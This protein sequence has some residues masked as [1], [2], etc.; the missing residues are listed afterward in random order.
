[1]N[2]TRHSSV[3]F[4]TPPAT[5]AQVDDRRLSGG[6]ALINDILDSLDDVVASGTGQG[7]IVLEVAEDLDANN[8]DLLCYTVRLGANSA[9]AM[10]PV[11]LG[12]LN[13]LLGRTRRHGR[14]HKPLRG[15]AF[16]LDMLVVDSRVDHIGDDALA[17]R[18][19]VVLVAIRGPLGHL[20]GWRR[21]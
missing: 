10:C 20:L 21:A 8:L 19:V 5:Q 1:M 3:K 6:L 14:G 2:G 17:G 13:T 18:F 12:I 7:M 9:S 11:N 16:K 15:P 4:I